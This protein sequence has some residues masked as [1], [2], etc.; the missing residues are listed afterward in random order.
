MRRCAPSSRPSFGYPAGLRRDEI[1]L[2]AQI[3]GIADMYHALLSTR[4]Y[5]DSTPFDEA[6]QV[7]MSTSGTSF[8]PSLVQTFVH[9]VPQYPAGLGVELSTGQVGIVSNPNSGQI[10]RPVVRVCVEK[11]G[12]VTEPYDLDLSLRTQLSTLVVDVQL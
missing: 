2:G 3:V 12:S 4:P 1:R 8:S 9:G 10:G 11:D 5:R 7:V 6:I